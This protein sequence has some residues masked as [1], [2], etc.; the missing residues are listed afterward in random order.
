MPLTEVH[1]I[2]NVPNLEQNRQIIQR[3]T[4]AMASIE[5]ENMGGRIWV[6]ISEVTSGEW[7]IER[8]REAGSHGPGR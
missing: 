6:K 1:L 8:R 4:G 7:G 5:S 2:E 3:L